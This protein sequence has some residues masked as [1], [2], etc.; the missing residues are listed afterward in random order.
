[1]EKNNTVRR[2][3][4]GVNVEDLAKKW[5]GARHICHHCKKTV[6]V[7]DTMMVVDK[8]DAYRNKRLCRDCVELFFKDELRELGIEGGRAELVL[9]WARKAK[10]GAY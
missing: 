10:E 4:G 6:R 2:V 5:L 8:K 7:R 3:R 9:K 1:M